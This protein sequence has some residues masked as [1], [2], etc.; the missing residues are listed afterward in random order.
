MSGTQD[1]VLAGGVQNMSSIP[2]S[3]AMIAGQ[4]FGLH[5]PDRR[6]RGLT[7]RFGDAEISQFVGA[8]MMA[9]K[10]DISRLDM[11]EWSLQ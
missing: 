5:H 4:E 6:V 10:W 8:D 7:E 11:E 2:I 9:K 1:V 3:Q